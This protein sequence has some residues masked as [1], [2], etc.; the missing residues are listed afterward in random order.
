MRNVIELLLVGII[1]FIGIYYVFYNYA[2]DWFCETK[3]DNYIWCVNTMVCEYKKLEDQNPLTC[4][5]KKSI[6]FEKDSFLYKKETYIN[7]Y[8]NYWESIRN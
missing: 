2:I 6:L 1:F 7:I 5:K 8:N 3:N 4:N